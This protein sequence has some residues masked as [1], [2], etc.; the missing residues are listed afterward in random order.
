[1]FETRQTRDLQDLVKKYQD[2]A[3]RVISS[4]FDCSLE[5]AYRIAPI[6]IFARQYDIEETNNIQFTDL[7]EA[8]FLSLAH[9]EDAYNE[10]LDDCCVSEHSED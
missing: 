6:I 10:Y 8:S 3:A 5:V 7:E 2:D 9:F 4:Y 1:M